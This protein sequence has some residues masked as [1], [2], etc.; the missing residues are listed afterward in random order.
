VAQELL[1]FD[2]DAA[3]LLFDH[4]VPDQ[5]LEY[6]FPRGFLPTCDAPQTEKGPPR[7][8]GDR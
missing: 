6:G 8:G 2:F 4:E 3:V 7:T 1:A 5:I